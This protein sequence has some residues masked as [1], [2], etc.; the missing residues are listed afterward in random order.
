MQPSKT[1]P[2]AN[3]KEFRSIF[4]DRTFKLETI[5]TNNYRSKDQNI[6]TD[7]DEFCNYGNLTSNDYFEY[8][9]N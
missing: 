8:H 4:R 2:L 1:I 9:L 3:Q 5:P 7:F 6:F